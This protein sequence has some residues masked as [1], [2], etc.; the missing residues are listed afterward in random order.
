MFT[1]DRDSPV[2]PFEQVKTS[3]ISAIEGGSLAPHAQLPTVRG[4]ATDLG[5]APG[6]VARAYRELEEMGLLETRGRNGT[7]VSLHG[8]AAQRAIQSAAADYAALAMSLQISATDAM[9][10]VRRALKL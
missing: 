3:I 4:L 1:I 2:S 6:T 8:D 9:D 5:V 10:A 7:F